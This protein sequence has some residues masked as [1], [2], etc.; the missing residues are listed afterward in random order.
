MNST[1]LTRTAEK[2]ATAEGNAK[3]SD[4]PGRRLTLRFAIGSLRRLSPHAFRLLPGRRHK[5]PRSNALE[6]RVGCGIAFSMR[7]VFA[8]VAV[9]SGDSGFRPRA[10]SREFLQTHFKI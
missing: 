1:F 8:D 10:P 9:Q 6:D 2:D 3:D 4:Q 7:V 5:Q